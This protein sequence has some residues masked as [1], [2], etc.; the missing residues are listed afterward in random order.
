M[1]TR[2]AIEGYLL[3]GPWIVGFLCF[4]LG[5]M[6]ASLYFSFTQYNIV[7]PP[8]FIGLDNYVRAFGGQDQLFF[9][10]LLRTLEYAVLYTPAGVVISL[11]LAVLL[12]RR[13]VGVSIFRTL[14]FMPTLTPVAATA[15]LWTWLLQ[16]DVGPVN[17]LLG[18]IGIQGPRWLASEQWALPTLVLAALWGSVGGS[19][20]IIFLAGLQGVPQELYE[21]ASI[22]GANWRQRLRHVTLPM[23]S[24]VTFFLVLLTALGAL[25]VF[26]LAFIATNG[27]PAYA[28]WFYLLQLYT[29]AFQSFYMGYASAL[30]WIFFVLVLAFTFLQFRLSRS[31]VHYAGQK[32]N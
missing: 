17:Y 1:A 10:S 26:A 5:P 20:M 2:E 12:N 31:W 9:P 3:I 16:P 24:P 15:L 22:D 21:A 19:R 23:I 14:F 4:T 25:R 7:K 18:Q 28:T 32:E 6:L 8:R 29:T 13:L 30:A 27:G 11:L